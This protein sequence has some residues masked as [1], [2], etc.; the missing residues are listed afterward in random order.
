MRVVEGVNVGL[1]WPEIKLLAGRDGAGRDVLVLRGAEPDHNWRSFIDAVM[2]LAQRFKVTRMIG[3][4]ASPRRCRIRAR[5][6]CRLPPRT[7]TWCLWVHR[8]QP[9]TFPRVWN[10]PSNEG[11][12]LSI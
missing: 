6:G 3:L 5:L 2:A 4:G 11:F 1:D 8:R 10:P 12:E 9:S 7:P